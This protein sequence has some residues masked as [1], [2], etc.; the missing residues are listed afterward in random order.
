MKESKVDKAIKKLARE[1]A[2]EAELAMALEKYMTPGNA[3][4]DPDFDAEIRRLRP[5]WFVVEE[6][7]AGR[8]V[9]CYTV[10]VQREM[11]K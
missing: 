10:P 9:H 11:E 6:K 3:E 7:P 2:R 4:Y 1:V 8:V 5:D